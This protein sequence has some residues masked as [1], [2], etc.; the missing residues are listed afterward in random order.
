LGPVLLQLPPN[1]PADP[2]V[3]DEAL[4]RFPAVVRVAVEP[5]HDSWW[6]GR[7]R[8]VLESRNAALCWADRKGRPMTPRWR[9]ADWG[10]LRLHEGTA[11]PRPRYGRQALT[12]WIERL[13][14]T[15]GTLDAY[16]YFN[17]DPGGAAITD[18]VV[19]AGV[20]ELRGMNVTRWPAASDAPYVRRAR[21]SA[22]ARRSTR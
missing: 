19:F 10:Y 13:H 3:L 20:A 2:D 4:R 18:A 11:V 6:S 22:S 15:Y 8:Q 21:S 17:N 9:T 7:V 5:R 14:D 12:S 16:V 1:L